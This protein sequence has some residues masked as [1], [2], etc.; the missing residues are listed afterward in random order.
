MT[1]SR[2]CM[3]RGNRGI[4]K[5]AAKRILANKIREISQRADKFSMGA[6]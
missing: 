4:A 2:A 1:D 3:G 6:A 5:A